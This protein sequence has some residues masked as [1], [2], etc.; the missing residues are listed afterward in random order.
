[1]FIIFYFSA[2]RS[3]TARS[4]SNRTSALSCR[5]TSLRCLS[6]S[7]AS[8]DFIISPTKAKLYLLF[9]ETSWLLSSPGGEEDALLGGE[10]TAPIELGSAMDELQG[11]EARSTGGTMAGL[12]PSSS[13]MAEYHG[14]EAAVSS[15]LSV[16][17]PVGGHFSSYR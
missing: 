2:N 13:S 12:W 17:V 8:D 3:I 14:H 10:D 9:L 1:M 6:I 4:L 16:P 7:K 11:K 5:S 15:P